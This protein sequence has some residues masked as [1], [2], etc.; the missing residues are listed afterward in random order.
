LGGVDAAALTRPSPEVEIAHN[1]HFEPS[2]AQDK[3]GRHTGAKQL[4]AID[5]SLHPACRHK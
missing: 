3:F 4:E 2:D 1:A 5:F